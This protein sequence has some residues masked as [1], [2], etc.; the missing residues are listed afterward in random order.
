MLIH[1]GKK[2]AKKGFQRKFKTVKGDII[3][4]W[5]EPIQVFQSVTT[6]VKKKG[7]KRNVPHTE[8]ETEQPR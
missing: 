4:K 2:K 5:G 8:H 3:L 6:T 1:I 7:K